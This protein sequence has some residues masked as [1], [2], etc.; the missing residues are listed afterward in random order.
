MKKSIQNLMLTACVFIFACLSMNASETK[1]VKFD[2]AHYPISG[3]HKKLDLK[4]TDCHRENKPEEYSSIT[5]D[6]C[7]ACHKSPES[8]AE[9]TSHLGHI[10][11]IHNSPHWGL[12]LSCDNCHKSHKEPVNMCLQ[13]HGQ[14]TLKNLI[15]K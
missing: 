13:C 14:K 7:F 3:I 11:N 2:D 1:T 5:Y 15:V 6:S 9:R 12:E 4:C 8:V 10:N